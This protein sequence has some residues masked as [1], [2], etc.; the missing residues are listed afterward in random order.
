MA[1]TK[2][3]EKG[4]RYRAIQK[5]SDQEVSGKLSKKAVWTKWVICGLLLVTASADF[6]S[7]ALERKFRI[8]DMSLLTIWTD[9]IL[10]IFLVKFAVIGGLIY[11]LV[12]VRKASDYLR[13]LWLMMAVYLI[14]FQTVGFISNRQVAEANPPLESA[15]SVEVRI[16]TGFNFSLIWAYWPIC[17][18][19]LSFWLWNIGWRNERA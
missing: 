13:Y 6:I 15:P 16:K 10:I 9:N 14:L 17:F 3:L 1:T 8:F 19:M 4:M 2:L 11:L 12:G 5:K 7:F 18:S